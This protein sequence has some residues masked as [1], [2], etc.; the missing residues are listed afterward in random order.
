MRR[1]HPLDAEHPAYDPGACGPEGRPLCPRCLAE[2]PVRTVGGFCSP[3]CRAEF[4]LRSSA[5][6]ARQQ[7][8]MRDG[9]VC[10][11]C[12]LDGG[13]LDRILRSLAES[14]G[15]D[16]AC[17]AMEVLGLGR[18]SRLISVWQMDHRLAV[19]E[20]GGICGLGNLRTLC[21]ECHQ[22]ETRL[23]HERMRRSRTA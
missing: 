16:V 18:R 9:G 17:W 2:L 13:R 3:V 20:G 5:A 10:T 8:F 1:H 21:L 7:V 15:E 19:T 14:A 23:L 11:H 4:K 22:R 6:Y 12:R